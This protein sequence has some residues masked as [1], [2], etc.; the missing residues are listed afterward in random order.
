M[1]GIVN[2][3]KPT[4]MTSSDA[5]V[6]I[7]GILK[8]K[9]GN[10]LKVG[11]LGT[12]DPGAS[13]VLPIAVGRAT[14][15]F[16]L[17]NNNHKCYRAAITFGKATDT[18]D[19]YGK[20]TKVKDHIPSKQQFIDALPAFIGN[21]EQIPPK[22]SA[23]N[24]QGKRAYELARENKEFTIQRRNV[25]INN[26]GFIE[27]LN[28]KTFVID[29]DCMG[30]TYIRS[31]VRDIAASLDSPA[32][33]SFLIRIKSNGLDLSKSVTL[34]EFQKNTELLPVESIL[35]DYIKYDID[36]SYKQKLLN[37]VPIEINN[38]PNRDFLVY[39]ENELFAVAH[40]EGARLIID[41]RL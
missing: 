15:L 13:G 6:R 36:T 24:I 11:H 14:K 12:L 5:V 31:L 22:Y 25:I 17:E 40:K 37:G 35:R 38:L 16:K 2:L 33:M 26:I 34:E 10:K 21:I 39:L 7:R 4:G 3:L 8:S 30:G 23:V 19:S 9:T 28:E 41:I 20:V 27:Q 32:Y 1:K 29:I 18:L